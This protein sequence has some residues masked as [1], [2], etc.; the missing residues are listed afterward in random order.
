MVA[1]TPMRTT[2]RHVTQR[3]LRI[4]LFGIVTAAWLAAPAAAAY[5]F[6]SWTADDGLPQNIVTA[7][8]QTRDGYLWIATL[9]GLA[10]FDG[11][12]FTVFTRSNS[13]GIETNRFTAIHEDIHG[14][15]W[16]GTETGVV[17]RYRH[18]RFVS[19]TSA[20]GLPQL[21]VKGFTANDD[22]E[23]WVLSGG[24]IQQWHAATGRFVD[25]EAPTVRTG[26][27]PMAWETRGGFWGVGPGGLHR[28]AGGHWSRHAIDETLQA[29]VQLAGQAPDGALW[30]AGPAMVPTRVGPHVAGGAH[31]ATV[32]WR[33]H[34]GGTWAFA[35]TPALDRSLTLDG[36][37]TSETIEFTTLYEGRDGDIWLGTNGRGLHRVR[38][39]VVTVYSTAQGLTDGNIYAVLQDRAG[40]M[41]LG[42]WTGGLHR[43]ADGRFTTYTTEDGL[44][45]N[46]VLA[47]AEGRDGR[48]W[49]ASIGGLQTFDGRRFTDVFRTFDDRDTGVRAIHE[50]PAG[51][52]WYGTDT[53]LVRLHDGATTRFSTGDGLVGDDVRVIIDA[54]RGGLWVGGLDG[55][56]HVQGGVLTVPQ[57][58]ESLRGGTVRALYED[59]DGVLWIGT[60]DNGLG[61]LQD[62]HFTRYTTRDGL[63]NDGVF[64]ILEDTRGRLWM[65]SN[66]GIS[67]VGKQELTD[68]SAGRR[69]RITSVGYGRKDGL[70]NAEC[71]GGVWPAGVRAADGRLWFPT[72]NGV[73]VVDPATI[74]DEAGPPAVVIESALVENASVDAA[75]LGD[76]LQVRPGQRHFEIQYTG[77]SFGDAE[78]LRFRYR[79]D[80]L[81]DHWTDAGTRRVAYYSNVPPGRYTFMV[82]AATGDSVWSPD[83]ARLAILVSPP[84]YRTWWFLTLLALCSVGGFVLVYEA[85]VARA[86]RARARQQAFSHQLIASQERERQRV[87]A[88][89]HDSLGQS[90]A[91]IKNRALAGLREQGAHEQALEQL[92]EIADA[93]D[94]AMDETQTIAYGLRPAQVDRVGITRAIEGMV[95]RVADA[96]DVRFTVAV[97]PLDGVLPH[98]AE[99]HVFRIVQEGVNNI[100]A[101]AQATD[102]TV[103]VHRHSDRIEVRIEDNGRGFVPN[104]RT[105]A[106]STRGFGLAGMAERARLAHG[107]CRIQSVPGSGTIV[108]V[109]IDVS[110]SS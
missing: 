47:L 25:I 109:A 50:D 1:D 8:T 31:D 3:L 98:D 49:V 10:R 103:C 67:R 59:R 86:E 76:V 106:T 44:A 54:A 14:D 83:A 81:D 79:L 63:F 34:A 100:V 95:A 101:H 58:L 46:Q 53:G 24:T 108:T 37:G 57:G 60:Y 97:D 71:N 70:L 89:L 18:G 13:P 105:P 4:C 91:I 5:R 7:I 32:T 72:Q 77:L 42:T 48:L 82:T 56:T 22:G 21:F 17:T 62:G 6:D 66:R 64:Q 30:L 52:L 33:M 55:V 110:K 99:I 90:L 2:V 12:R 43:F 28:F 94:D 40:A 74:A 39:Q 45:A 35:L 26:Y 84:F 85:R 15:L 38:E 23:F 78:R 88:E 19:Y 69:S 96:H 87:A 68:V 9:D 41:W 107:V 51:A 16:L 27:H 75:R 104:D 102:A 73:A 11:V 36:T 20:H 80:G 65:S 93:A 92:R 61:R 29:R